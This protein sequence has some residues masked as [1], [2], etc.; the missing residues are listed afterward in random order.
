MSSQIIVIKQIIVI[1]W[2]RWS[3]GLPEKCFRPPLASQ[4][5]AVVLNKVQYSSL[6]SANTDS[7][8]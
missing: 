3:G 6:I 2:A 5:D 4:L 1:T 7:L 8:S